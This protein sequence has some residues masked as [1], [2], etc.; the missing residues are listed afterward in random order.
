MANDELMIDNTGGE[1]TPKQ[2]EE[3]VGSQIVG[4][5][6]RTLQAL[7]DALAR[8]KPIIGMPLQALFNT[9]EY[10]ARQAGYQM[11]KERLNEYME[12]KDLRE[13]KRRNDEEAERI[14]GEQMPQEAATN[15]AKLKADEASAKARSAATPGQQAILQENQDQVYYD[16]KLNRA[17]ANFWKRFANGMSGNL[18][19]DEVEN[20]RKQHPVEFKMFF[21]ATTAFEL[22]Q[23]A[24]SGDKNAEGLLDRWCRKNSLRYVKGSDGVPML[25]RAGGGENGEDVPVLELTPDG[26]KRFYQSTQNPVVAE[27][28]A[29]KALSDQSVSGNPAMRSLAD[30]IKAFAPYCGNSYMRATKVVQSVMNDMEKRDPEYA[31]NFAVHNCLQALSDFRSGKPGAMQELFSCIAPNDKAPQGELAKLGITI[32][33]MDPAKLTPE[34]IK[35]LTPEEIKNFT[36]RIE[37][38][39]GLMTF[40]ELYDHLRENDVFG[41]KMQERLG[42][43]QEASLMSMMRNARSRGAGLPNGSGT[44]RTGKTSAPEAQEPQ[45]ADEKANAEWLAQGQEL[46]RMSGVNIPLI[47]QKMRGNKAFKIQ[48]EEDLYRNFALAAEKATDAFEETGKYSDAYKAFADHL[49]GKGVSE[50]LIPNLW[51]KDI[52][53]QDISET[54]R[55][56]EHLDRAYLHRSNDPKFT[57]SSGTVVGTDADITE[58]PSDAEVNRTAHREAAKKLAV[59]SEKYN[60]LKKE[61]QDFSSNVKKRQKTRNTLFQRRK[62]GN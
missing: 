33:G 29:R 20:L 2:E 22:F 1:F 62:R 42:F 49:K 55:K 58:G 43:L 21:E 39:D 37:G 53:E 7:P 3:S 46:S 61:E 59:L 35:K 8:Q 60:A 48:S 17:Q 4:A 19:Y 5:L 57:S 26:L 18:S 54:R 6:G 41:R 27:I 25:M 36:F 34:E 11:A 44:G 38:K 30:K 50:S 31:R 23:D 51:E 45:T 28:N 32:N 16:A 13:L 40:D 24:L 15:L 9:D 47:Y 52:L 12:G 10:Q 56:M 14:R